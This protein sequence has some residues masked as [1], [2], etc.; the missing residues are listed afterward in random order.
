M[1]GKVAVLGSADFVM[2]FSALGVDTYLAG[3]TDEEMAETVVAENIAPAIQ[4][5]FS[6]QMDAAIPCIVVV[7]FTTE[8]EGFATQA[9]AQVLKIATGVNIMQ[10]N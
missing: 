2:P 4:E 7:P 6:A 3:Q 1:E 8:S 5:A 10:D 9:L